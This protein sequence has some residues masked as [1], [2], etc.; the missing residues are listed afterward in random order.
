MTNLDD[1]PSQAD[2]EEG[3]GPDLEY[4]VRKDPLSGGGDGYE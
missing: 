3:V 2:F 1:S 4:L